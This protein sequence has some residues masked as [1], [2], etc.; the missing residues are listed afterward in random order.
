MPSEVTSD[1]FIGIVGTRHRKEVRGGC[2]FVST[3][4]VGHIQVFRIDKFARTIIDSLNYSCGKYKS[5]LDAYVLMPSHLHLIVK[6][7]D[8]MSLSDLMRDFK[9]FTSV[10]IKKILYASDAYGDIRRKLAGYAP[11]SSNRTFKLWADRFDDAAI[12]SEEVY[13]TKLNYI[14]NNPLKAGLVERPEDYKYSSFYDPDF[15]GGRQK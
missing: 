4:V 1:G 6:M 2:F 8:Q 14:R 12:Y 3:S 11:K 7:N 9:K 13:L 5:I 15:Q 10:A